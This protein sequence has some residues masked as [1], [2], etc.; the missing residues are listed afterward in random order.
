L[1]E[2]EKIKPFVCYRGRTSKA[3]PWSWS[4]AG[5]P[6]YCLH[7][8]VNEILMIE[9]GGWPLRVTEYNPDD[10]NPVPGSSTKIPR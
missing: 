1:Y 8:A 7:C 6:Y 3:Y 5:V 2:L 4:Q 10:T 9:W